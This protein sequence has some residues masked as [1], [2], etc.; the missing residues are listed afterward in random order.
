MQEIKIYFL[1]PTNGKEQS[2]DL[3]PALKVSEIIEELIKAGFMKPNPQGYDLA[4]P[5]GKMLHSSRSLAEENIS[6]GTTL[7]VIPATDAGQ[8]HKS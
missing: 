8:L 7:R 5:Q 4:V 2:A 1:H 6:S 3:D